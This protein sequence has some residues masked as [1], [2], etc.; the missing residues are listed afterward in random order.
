MTKRLFILFFIFGVLFQGTMIFLPASI[1]RDEGIDQ[2]YLGVKGFNIPPFFQKDI[3]PHASMLRGTHRYFTTYHLWPVALSYAILKPARIIYR[4]FMFAYIM[5]FVFAFYRLARIW[6]NDEVAYIAAIFALFSSAIADSVTLAHITGIAFPYFAIYLAETKRQRH[7]YVC[8]FI[9]ALS[10]YAYPTARL[11]I[12]GYVIAFCVSR[13]DECRARWLPSCFFIVLLLPLVVMAYLFP[14]GIPATLLVSF[15][16]FLEK[17]KMA[18]WYKIETGDINA[19]LG[20]RV[21][22]PTLSISTAIYLAFLCKRFLGIAWIGRKKYFGYV[23]F[24][25]LIAIFIV[26]IYFI[27]YLQSRLVVWA[28]PSFFLLAAALLYKLS[29]AF[30]RRKFQFYFLLPCLLFYAGMEVPPHLKKITHPAINGYYA[31]GADKI[32]PY[33]L[34][35]NPKK[36]FVDYYMSD[37]LRVYSGGRLNIDQVG[38]DQFNSATF[39]WE[40]GTKFEGEGCFVFWKNSSRLSEF[41]DICAKKSWNYNLKKEFDFPEHKSGI[42]IYEVT[43]G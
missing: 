14:Q 31:Y 42:V 29:L 35:E 24:V 32:L 26:F 7:P 39:P 16:D 2:R 9:L 3:M 23:F 21:I 38:Y 40:L 19:P 41:L 25:T 4:F 5:L 18:F 33:L 28:M 30:K 6:F 12:A 17:A 11:V 1:H 34:K 20:Q 10:A 43:G 36:I 8:G 27:P 15:K 22:N 13:W 37:I